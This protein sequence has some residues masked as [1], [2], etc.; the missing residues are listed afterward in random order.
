[1][2]VHLKCYD[3][4]LKIY[5][6]GLVKETKYKR[7]IICDKQE[8][9]FDEIV[10]KGRVSSSIEKEFKEVRSDSL[11]RTR[12]LLIDYACE[13]ES[14]FKSFITLTFAENVTDINEANKK[15][16]DWRTSITRSLKK[17]NKDF[18]YLG[19]PEF[20]KRGAV[21][22]HLLTN[23]EVNGDYLTLQHG[24][25]NMYDVKYWKYG[26][27]SAFDIMRNTDDNFNIA[28]Y[29]CKYL[30]KDIDNRLFGRNKCLKSNN[31]KKPLTAKLEAS[32]DTYK[33]AKSYI[34]SKCYNLCDYYCF[35]GN[36]ENKYL[37]PYE[38]FSYNTHTDNSILKDIL[39]HK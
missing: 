6:N 9:E 28:L 38:L 32:S 8:N 25:E 30:Y 3:R 7:S 18:K 13:N 34:E 36:D 26:F 4:K 29:I 5:S 19:V 16:H 14:E 37:I 2:N 17:D 31:L 1:M 12:N 23:L 11:S 21:H 22:Y 27:S 24:K 33:T 10:N 35:D 39:Q 20:Q 15:F